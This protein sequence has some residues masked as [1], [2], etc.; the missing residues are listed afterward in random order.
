[1]TSKK[2]Q[3]FISVVVPVFNEEMNIAQFY[4]ALTAAFAGVDC[5]LE[6][7]FVDDGSNDSTF[8]LLR[9]LALRDSRVRALQFSRNF[10]SHAAITAGLHQARGDAAVIISVDLQDPPDLIRAFIDK[11]SEGFHVVWGVRA[12]REDPWSKKLYARI[13]YGLIRKIA[14]PHYPPEGM[15]FGLID[16]KVIQAFNG[17]H[18]ANRLVT[19]M[20]VWAGF[21]Q[22]TI[23]YHRSARERGVSKWSIGKR[24]KSAIDV[25]VSFSYFP[26]RF[27]SYLGILVS[28]L[29]FLYAAFLI[30]RRFVFGLGGAGW[31]SVMVTVLFLGGIQLIVLG[32]LGEYIWRTSDQVRSRPLYI[33]MEEVGGEERTSEDRDVLE[34]R[35]RG[36][37]G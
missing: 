31:P 13:F 5:R 3:P 35:P 19:A 21:R 32:V 22:A 29:S 27:I 7:I 9:E 10:G 2:R 37:N 25:I 18:E 1:M 11:W 12:S 14:L 36:A 26:I 34:A 8:L 17:F 20:L 33:V 16:R 6:V 23:P 30:F 15:D 28:L 4:N 24:V